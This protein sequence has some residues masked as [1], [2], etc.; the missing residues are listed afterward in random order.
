MK[1]P[2]FPFKIKTFFRLFTCII[3]VEE[4]SKIGQQKFENLQKDQKMLDFQKFEENYF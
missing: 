3:S 2:D 4:K 1:P